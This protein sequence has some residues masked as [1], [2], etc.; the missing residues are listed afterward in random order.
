MRD[1]RKLVD[2]CAERY[3]IRSLCAGT[4]VAFAMLYSLGLL[5]RNREHLAELVHRY[6]DSVSHP[7]VWAVLLT[8][9]A[10][11][12]LGF[13]LA[14]IGLIHIYRARRAP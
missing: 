11:F 10:V 6:P 3:P 8:G 2:I 14:S 13:R 5:H 12:M 7:A 1:P 9:G 4:G